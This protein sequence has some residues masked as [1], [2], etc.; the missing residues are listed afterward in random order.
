MINAVFCAKE[1]W[2]RP[3]K[4][5]AFVTAMVGAGVVLSSGS[6]AFAD[7]LTCF[8]LHCIIGNIAAATK[9]YGEIRVD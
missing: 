3:S 6:L 5:L 1:C 4:T 2:N 7:L 9:R 8:Y